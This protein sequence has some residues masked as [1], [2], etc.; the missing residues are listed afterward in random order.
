MQ[1]QSRLF[2]EIAKLMTTAAG[3]A[4]GAAREVET[5]LRSQVERLVGEFDLIGREDFEALKALTEKLRTE[6]EALKARID[7]LEQ[8]LEG[9]AG[10]PLPAARKARPAKKPR[11]GA[12]RS[13][14]ARKR[15]S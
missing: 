13:R 14:R 2:D 15:A 9:R 1:T 10:R 4:Q 8:T 3:A 7:D 11:S 12:A 5:L 6:N